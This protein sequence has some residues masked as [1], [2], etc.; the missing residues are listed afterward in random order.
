MENSPKKSKAFIITFIIIL[1]LLLVGY[2]LYKNRTQIFSTKGSSTVNRIFSPLLGT[3]KD[4]TVDMVPNQ[5]S[6]KNKIVDVITT[7][8][9]YGNKVILAEAGEDISRGDAVYISGFND[10]GKPIIMKAIA[11]DKNKSLV[12]GVAG[13]NIPKGSTGNIIIEGQL[14]NFNTS[15]K[16]GTIWAVNNPLYLS[17]TIYGGM[18]KNAPKTP[19]FTVAI[20]GVVKVDPITGII[21][22]GD[23]SNSLNK[24]S[25]KNL[26]TQLLKD[27]SL[28]GLSAF[29]VAVFGADSYK[30]LVYDTN[31]NSFDF[32]GYDTGGGFVFNPITLP[33]TSTGSTT[34]T[35]NTGTSTETGTGTGTTDT[36][37]G[38]SSKDTSSTENKCLLIEQNPLEFTADEKARLDTLLRKFY[39]ISSSLRTTDDIA[40]IYNEI[41]QQNIFI[42]QTKNLT[43][44]CYAQ[45]DYAA[46]GNKMNAGYGWIRHGNPWYS[47]ST[48]GSFPYTNE[49]TGY[50]S[51]GWID[52]INMPAIER[53][54]NIW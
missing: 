41:E 35:T 5:E 7:V 24:D 53:L 32:T 11:N 17:D 26:N 44:Q 9:Q 51:Q 8:D 12:L 10:N 13:E 27:S 39:L 22:I 45:I 1:I 50:T 40:T 52:D 30:G 43:A 48:G 6:N 34:G 49:N 47:V 46:S 19:S 31:G 38:T 42:N 15:R 33:N 36:E 14:N 29:W 16:E 25:N 4:K 54:L 18:T 21:Q 3:S 20:G 23:L 2:Y 28:A 37:T